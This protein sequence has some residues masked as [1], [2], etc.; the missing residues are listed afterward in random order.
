ITNHEI[1][2]FN[3][4]AY[5]GLTL[6]KMIELSTKRGEASG[7]FEFYPKQVN[8]Q[9]VAQLKEVLLMDSQGIQHEEIF[10]N[11][12]M[13]PYYEKYV[14]LVEEFRILDYTQPAVDK[15]G[16]PFSREQAYWDC[17]QSNLESFIKSAN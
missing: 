10:K 2:K 15:E 17:L 11:H 14:N 5:R 6:E 12:F 7:W 9:T 1:I 8:K 13:Q 3:V 4:K 16:V